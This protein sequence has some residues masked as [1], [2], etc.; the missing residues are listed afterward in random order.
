MR[1]QKRHRSIKEPATWSRTNP[2]DRGN[3][4]TQQT[5]FPPSFKIHPRT[6]G[7]MGEHLGAKCRIHVCHPGVSEIDRH[8]EGT[9]SVRF[10]E[11]LL[12]PQGGAAS[13]VKELCVRGM[14]QGPSS[15]SLDKCIF[16]IHMVGMKYLPGRRKAPPGGEKPC[17]QSEEIPIRDKWQCRDGRGRGSVKGIRVLGEGCVPI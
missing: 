3:L 5:S 10:Q 9:F 6:T 1:P 8:G 7:P 12:Y 4:R 16:G 2:W 15:F 14:R 11:L 13:F 17:H